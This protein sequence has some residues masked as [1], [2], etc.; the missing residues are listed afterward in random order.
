MKKLIAI[1]LC[2]IIPF[3]QPCF[4]FASGEAESAEIDF[5]TENVQFSDFNDPDFL[6]YAED[7]VYASLE[8]DLHSDDY[9]IEDV[10]AIYIS[11]EY[12]EEVEFNTKSNLY[13]GYSLA[14]LDEFFEGS[15]YIFTLDENDKTVP[16]AFQ[17]FPDNTDALILKNIAI[18]T[19]VVLI[20]V[21]VTIAT[22]G[23]ATPGATAGAAQTIS[24][25][26]AASAKTATSFA[27]KGAALSAAGTAIIKG[28]ETGDVYETVRAASLSAS[29]GFK[30]GAITGAVAG[31]VEEGLRIKTIKSGKAPN[32]IT[33]EKNVIEAYDCPQ[34]QVPYINGE[35]VSSTTPGA[36]KPDGLR[37]IDGHWEAIEVKCYDLAKETHRSVLKKELT[38]QIADRCR[39]L[40]QGTTQRIV[41]DVEGRK[42]TKL[43]VDTIVK[44]IRSYL[45]PIYP[46]IPIDIFGEVL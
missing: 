33:A 1:I 46:N 37:F 13:F 14:Q 7:L 30:W 31:G 23:V 21:T 18:G 4:C 24:M 43:F 15:R 27:I 16:Q 41:L 45:D 26:F 25:I 35:R 39:H 9:I 8:N 42:Y 12:L 32:W 20:C 11:Q 5:S 38:R 3:T 28:F 2:I 22:A 40:P 10:A 29:E 6:Q 44:E 19:G 36:T 34:K 17:K